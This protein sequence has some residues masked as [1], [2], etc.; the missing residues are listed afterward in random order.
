MGDMA[1]VFNDLR[2]YKQEKRASNTVAST[3]MLVKAGIKFKSFNGGVHL[4]LDHAVGMVDFWPSTGLWMLRGTTKRQ[5]GVKNL[6]KFYGH[7]S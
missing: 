7:E 6:L 5:R 2:K 3:Q 4:V 1:E